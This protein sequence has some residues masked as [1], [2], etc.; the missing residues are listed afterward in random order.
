M[1]CLLSGVSIL[2]LV[3]IFITEPSA[4][5]S[6][7]PFRPG[8]SNGISIIHS[9]IFSNIDP[10]GIVSDNGRRLVITG[11]IKCTATQRT[12]IRVTVTQRFTGAVAEGLGFITCSGTLQQWEVNAATIGDELFEEGA[13][14]AVA[15]AL[16]TD[17]GAATDANQWLVNIT[18]V[19]E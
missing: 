3:I 6:A 11:P 17:R 1:I 16:P 9:N 15:L 13:A 7:L 5:L 2:T 10:V 18:L 12:D 14:T 4:N 8:V 19:E